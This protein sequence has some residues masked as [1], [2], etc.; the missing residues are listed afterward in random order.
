MDSIQTFQQFLTTQSV[1]VPIWS[2]IF[3][4]ILSAFLA[5]ILNHVYIKYG[6]SLSNRKQFGSNFIL[7]AMTTM[8]IIS[9]VKSSLALSL[10]LVGAL[11]I[12]RFRAAIKE[13]EELAYLFLCLAIGLGLGAD[14][15][16]ITIIAFFI[17]VCVVVAKGSFKKTKAG[18]NYYITLSCHKSGGNEMDDIIRVLKENCTSVN[19]RRFDETKEKMEAFFV[20]EFKEYEKLKNT[21]IALRS[22]NDSI[23]ITFMDHKDIL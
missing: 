21:N 19:M 10:G 13:P 4:L 7:L 6:K 1:Q 20:V 3:N 16:L 22:I 15:T 11:S 2:F 12:V 14:Q 23:K 18:I 17:I 9:I 5:Y 8:L